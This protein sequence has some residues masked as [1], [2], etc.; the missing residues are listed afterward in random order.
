MRQSLF[1]TDYGQDYARYINLVNSQGD[2]Q[3]SL[4]LKLCF[5]K[6]IMLY[7]FGGEYMAMFM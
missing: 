5:A 6:N 4:N 1:K 2:P 3:S 7:F